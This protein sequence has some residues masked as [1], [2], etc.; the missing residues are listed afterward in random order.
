[1]PSDNSWMMPNC[2]MA[3]MGESVSKSGSNS[4]CTLPARIQALKAGPSP[5]WLAAS[6]LF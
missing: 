4:G 2:N 1:M 5:A 6:L 3:K